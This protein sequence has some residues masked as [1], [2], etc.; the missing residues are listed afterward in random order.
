MHRISNTGHALRAFSFFWRCEKGG[1]L[2]LPFSYRST[3]RQGGPGGQDLGGGAQA[4]QD[5]HRERHPQPVAQ[6]VGQALRYVS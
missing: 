3:F 4:E 2:T 6:H 1:K 5:R